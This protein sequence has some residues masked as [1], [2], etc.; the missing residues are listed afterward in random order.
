METS[1]ELSQVL[2]PAKYKKE[3]L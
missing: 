1:N 3:C 2:I